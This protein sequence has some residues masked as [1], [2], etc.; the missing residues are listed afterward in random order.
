MSTTADKAVAPKKKTPIGVH[1]LAGGTAGMSEALVC[2]TSRCAELATRSA[3]FF[4]LADP[5]DTIKVRMQLSRSS[6]GK[7]V[8]LSARVL[9]KMAMRPV[10]FGMGWS[11]R[12]TA[13]E[14][15]IDG[16]VTI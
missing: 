7:G 16:I 10:K 13:Q 5:L 4:L 3:H 14:G 2:R 15:G 12:N 1:L 6:R 9:G 11:G 8:S